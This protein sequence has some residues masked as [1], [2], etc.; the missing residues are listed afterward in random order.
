[1]PCPHC[2]KILT[3][4]GKAPGQKDMCPHCFKAVDIAPRAITRSMLKWRA[5]FA[6]KYE[7]KQKKEEK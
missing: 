5:A 7:E 2:K 4:T 3:I 1:M 6:K